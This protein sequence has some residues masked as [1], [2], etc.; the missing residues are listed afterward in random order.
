MSVDHVTPSGLDQ[1]EK[2]EAC[3]RGSVRLDSI[4]TAF[5]PVVALDGLTLDIAHGEFLVLLGPSGCGKT[6]ALRTIA[7]LEDPSTG[8]V[9][10]GDRPMRDVDPK[11]R[12]VAMVFQNYAL[13]PHLTVAENIAFPLR[14]R[15]VAAAERRALVDEVAGLIGLSSLL[16]RKPA[17]LSGGERQRVA[18]ARAIVRRPQVFL[19]DE[20]LS[21]LDG[22][23]REAARAELADLHRRLGTTFV[24]VTHDQ[25]EA[26][27]LG[28][29]LALLDHGRLQQVGRP[30]DV[31]D[32]PANTFVAR[33][34]GN[35]A[36]NL[37]P[38]RIELHESG[39]VLRTDSNAIALQAWPR[40][41]AR[42]EVVVGVRPEQLT[43]GTPGWRVRVGS[44]E[45]HGHERI[46]RC[47]TFDGD[48]LCVRTPSTAP[49]PAAG[50]TLTVGANAARLHFFDP[51]TGARIGPNE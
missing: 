38:G 44:V 7:G 4:T 47:T 9:T 25:V 28:T 33:F 16:D 10:I 48:G 37:L 21:N 5:G 46:V 34:L 13:Y 36:M 43:I 12:D 22:P 20:P 51:A 15:R 18:L 40:G 31:F 45:S 3:G 50:E 24:F 30:D 14:R 17:Q 39:P 6:T 32:R 35:P 8:T 23:L 19:M 29:R 27:T 1:R 11:D 41:A 2:V 49:I 26:L 42:R